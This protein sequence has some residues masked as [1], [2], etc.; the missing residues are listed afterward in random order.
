MQYTPEQISSHNSETNVL[1]L[2]LTLYLL[3]QMETQKISSP[4]SSLIIGNINM[5]KKLDPSTVP[6]PKK[7]RGGITENDGNST[8]TYEAVTG[9][10]DGIA[11]S[12]KL[13]ND[14]QEL[15]VTSI[16]CGNSSIRK[17]RIDKTQIITIHFLTMRLNTISM[18]PYLT[19]WSLAITLNHA[20]YA[21][22][23]VYWPSLFGIITRR[24][25]Q[26]FNTS[27]DSLLSF[28]PLNTTKKEEEGQ[29]CIKG[30]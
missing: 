4:M 9:I 11:K 17:N 21:F 3:Y 22:C 1:I 15:I 20:L 2:A 16:V 27:M 28:M 14:A 29:C 23:H 19:I 26:L 24:C 5:V 7:T 12:C 30:C 6:F 13:I 18:I 8:E 10:A 25:K